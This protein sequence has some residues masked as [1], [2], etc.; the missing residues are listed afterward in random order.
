LSAAFAQTPPLYNITPIGLSGPNYT[1]T[2]ANGYTYQYSEAY[3]LTAAGQADG[4]SFRYDAN[5][6]ALGQDVWA[7]SNGVTHLAG[8]TGNNYSYSTANG[9][10]QYSSLSRFG[11][12]IDPAGQFFGETSR[13]AATGNTLGA[14]AWFYNGNSTQ[15]IGLAG[16]G[17]SYSTTGGIY[18]QDEE[19]DMN[20]VG[21]AIGGSA[22]YNASGN[23]LGDDAW[24]FSGTTSTAI[25]LTGGVY[26]YNY[27]GSGGGLVQ[28]SY[29]GVINDAGEAIGTS[30][31]FSS[32]GA[33]LGED[34]WFFNGSTTQA[35]GLTGANYSYAIAGSGNFEEI[36]VGLLSANGD[37]AGVSMRYNSTGTAN[38]GQDAWIFNGTTTQQVGLTGSQYHY[39]VTT[40]GGGIYESSGVVG[41]NNAGQ[42]VGFSDRYNSVGSMLGTDTWFFDGKTTQQIG[43]TGAG[44]SYTSTQPG[45]GIYEQS[46]PGALINN[47]GQVAG[48][49]TRFGSNGADLGG[50]TWFFNGTTTQSIGLTGPGYSYF[51][52]SGT[53]Q[54]SRAMTINDNP[55]AQVLGLSSRY[56]SS[57]NSLGQSAWF[58]DSA[59]GITTPLVFSI[60]DDGYAY[61]YPIA[62][63]D[64]GIVLGYYDLFSG[65]SNTID[66]FYWSEQYG[67]YDLGTMV[68]GGLTAAG[69]AQLTDADFA[70]GMLPDGSPQFLAGYGLLENFAGTSVFLMNAVPEPGIWESAAVGLLLANRRKRA[71]SKPLSRLR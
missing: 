35:I 3:G 41:L 47:A 61:T 53:V 36:V 59:T 70:G 33:N 42:A 24:F 13:Y 51:T 44:F 9:I 40:S 27:T 32:T 26:E 60:R 57:G 20:N 29:A 15:E 18:E 10:Y 28:T 4:Y 56:D 5:G 37:V 58:Y 43:L 49:S 12:T 63:T 67:F 55:N 23:N 16:S 11:V 7:E 64:T 39:T 54:S 66:A 17:Y 22:R 6:D 46:G 31:R 30:S 34:A 25:G 45:S 65:D 52:S 50:D 2:G 21:Q 19:Y 68:N 1:Y 38:L 14:D 8:L 62:L 48:G 69:W 71:R